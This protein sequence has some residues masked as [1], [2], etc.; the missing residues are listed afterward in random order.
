SAVPNSSQLTLSQATTS[1]GIQSLSVS[2]G[3]LSDA[4][5]VAAI[6]V[7]SPTLLAAQVSK[8]GKLAVFAANGAAPVNGA[9]PPAPILATV[10]APTLR[11][12]GPPV[13]IGDPIWCPATGDFPAVAYPLRCGSIQ[14]VAI[15]DGGA[16]YSSAPTASVSGGAI[17]GTPALAS[18]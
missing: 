9:Y 1:S 13:Q 17:L 8:S 15:V 11:R 10:A 18:G 5:Y 12:N 3:P 16:G 7:G 2:V 14:S 4:T 6:P